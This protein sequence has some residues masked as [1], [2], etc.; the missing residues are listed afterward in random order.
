MMRRLFLVFAVVISVGS[1]T[2][3][4]LEPPDIEDFVPG[5]NRIQP[6]ATSETGWLQAGSVGAWLGLP[7]AVTDLPLPLRLRLVWLPGPSSPS[8]ATVRSW[9]GNLPRRVPLVP[10]PYDGLQPL[11]AATAAAAAVHPPPP[12]VVS[13]RLQVE[14]VDVDALDPLLGSVFDELLLASARPDVPLDLDESQPGA[15]P[16]AEE[17]SEHAQ[18]EQFQVER[19]VL[20]PALRSLAALLDSLAPVSPEHLPAATL[21][22]LEP[23]SPVS[24]P[25]HHRYGYRFGPSEHELRVALRSEQLRHWPPP[26]VVPPAEE[27]R[28][29]PLAGWSPPVNASASVASEAWARRFLSRIGSN[30]SFF[31]NAEFTVAGWLDY[32]ISSSPTDRDTLSRLV[33]LGGVHGE[34]LQD[35]GVTDGRSAINF[36]VLCFL[37]CA[38]SAK[39]S[40]FRN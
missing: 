33:H 23:R 2:A 6:L 24:D 9:L 29:D 22:V 1:S 21:F 20:E 28:F 7:P 38:V 17:S 40:V 32:V 4:V 15:H 8:A 13:L 19:R 3:G 26:S 37:C 12:S 10:L 11:S 27:S 36:F 14:V 34:C 35:T 16:D 30:L 31:S 18:L 39:L 5:S 25:R